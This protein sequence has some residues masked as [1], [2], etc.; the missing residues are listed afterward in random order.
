MQKATSAVTRI[1][2]ATA[3]VST[4]VTE[5]KRKL[6]G[7]PL[8]KQL[9]FDTTRKWLRFCDVVLHLPTIVHHDKQGDFTVDYCGEFDA[10]ELAFAAIERMRDEREASQRDSQFLWHTI[11][12][13]GVTPEKSGRYGDSGFENKGEP[14]ILDQM[15]ICRCR[16][17]T[18]K[19][20]DILAVARESE[21]LV[22]STRTLTKNAK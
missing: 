3:G 18:V 5:Y 21:R 17:D 12:R 7:Y 20:G 6:Y 13:N 11:P 19:R 10:E 8:W 22:Q 4:L 16:P 1:P 9:I 2:L 14:G 15:V